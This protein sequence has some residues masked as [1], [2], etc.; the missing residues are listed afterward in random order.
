M[1]FVLVAGTTET[2]RIEGISAAG[3]DPGA[4]RTTPTADAEILLEGKPIDAPTVPV[5]PS[6]CPTPALVTRAVRELVGFE[7]EVIDAGMA[8]E[9][10]ITTRSVASD[11]GGDART[12]EPVPNAGAIWDRSRTI[13][14]DLASKSDDRL[15]VGETIPGGTTTALGVARALGVDLSV[16]SSLPEN[17]TERKGAVV[18]AGLA[19]SGFETGD[20]AGDPRRAVR[21]QGDPVLASVA[22]LVAGALSAG[23]SVTLAGG[24]QLIAAASLVRHAGIEAPLELATTSYVADDP[25]ASVET[26]ADALDLSLTATDPEFEDCGHAGIER[27]AAGEGKEG[28]GMGGGLTL[29]RRRGIDLDAVRDRTVTLYD[30]L[31]GA[32]S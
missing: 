27:F 20:L 7:V 32:P 12:A 21:S 13:G 4:M 16:S 17:P 31:L 25:T 23:T 28:V 11:S 19:E 1:T 5:S 2:A 24:T 9:P 18:E 30:R 6:G 26:T 14:E 3:A 22:G 10:G 8:V 29:A 15:Y